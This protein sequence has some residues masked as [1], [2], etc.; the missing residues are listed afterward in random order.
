M[1]FVS[2]NPVL[3]VC[4]D[5]L[6][7]SINAEAGGADRVELC[8]NLTEGGTTPSAG[9]I[10]MVRAKITIGL[11][12]MIRP[13][14][15]D[16]L[17]SE[18]EFELMKH[19]IL[20]ARELGVDGIVLGCLTREGTIDIVKLSKFMEIARPM[21]VTFH[22]AF[23]MVRDPFQALEELIQVGVNRILTSGQEQT[24][25]E[26]APPLSN[27]VKQA[28]DRVVI[29]AGGGIRP[30]NIKEIIASTGVN[31]CHVSANKRIDSEMDFRNPRITMGKLP[32]SEYQHTIV[33]VEI[34][35]AFR[36]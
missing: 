27:L 10:R 13:R 12:V 7:S 34:V 17:Y 21:N 29:M 15:G 26:G 35:R 3:E 22:R 11:Q 28:G 9:M 36:K 32:D 8:D 2:K 14:G 30:H 5:S 19:D 16:F 20:L 31:E 4:I 23:D 25:L 24:A 6:T 18:D 1:S 33:D